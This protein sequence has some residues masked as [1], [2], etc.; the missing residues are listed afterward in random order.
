MRHCLIMRLI[1]RS[2]DLGLPSQVIIIQ[3]NTSFKNERIAKL[4]ALL[5]TALLR[6]NGDD[7]PFRLQILITSLYGQSVDRT[8][9][10]RFVS[11]RLQTG[12]GMKDLLRSITRYQA[13]RRLP[14]LLSSLLLG[15]GRE[16]K[17]TH[18]SL[19]IVA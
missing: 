10:C 5:Y 19:P 4:I 3:R 17:K 2:S 14:S 12:K 7:L 6:Y 8:V 11:G 9:T 13:Q 15:P 1:T 18:Q 16:R